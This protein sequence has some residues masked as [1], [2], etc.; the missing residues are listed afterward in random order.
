MYAARCSVHPMPIDKN[1]NPRKKTKCRLCRK[2]S[3]TGSL[4]DLTVA[5]DKEVTLPSNI[6][7]YL[8]MRI[9]KIV[10]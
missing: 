9:K 3:K 5:R 4:D 7:D 2:L 6:S 10:Y 1:R 8:H